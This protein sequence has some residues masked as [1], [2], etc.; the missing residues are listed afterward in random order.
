MVWLFISTAM[1]NPFTPAGIAWKSTSEKVDESHLPVELALMRRLKDESPGWPFVYTDAITSRVA[2][3][4]TAI[5]KTNSSLTGLIDFLDRDNLE[6]VPRQ[7][8]WWGPFLVIHDDEESYSQTRS[9]MVRYHQ[10]TPIEAVFVEQ[11]WFSTE[12]NAM[13]SSED[14][15]ESL[16]IEKIVIL[17]HNGHPVAFYEHESTLT[18]YPK[19]TEQQWA[20]RELT[21][22]DWAK[23]LTE[24]RSRVNEYIQLFSYHEDGSL[25]RIDAYWIIPSITVTH[26]IYTPQPIKP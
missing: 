26:S 15:D 25:A 19:Y 14:Y 3:R 11:H 13:Y 6:L 18:Y 7:E 24:P 20:G 12:K 17:Y 21:T 10:E 1:A 2:M 8:G 5:R 23:V 16:S 4:G 9:G 22:P